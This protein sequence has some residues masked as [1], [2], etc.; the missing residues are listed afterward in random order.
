M[1]FV[2]RFVECLA[3]K[4]PQINYKGM[5]IMLNWI[6]KK[7]EKK[8]LNELGGIPIL[9]LVYQPNK[10][11]PNMEYKLHPSIKHDEY[12]KNQF[13]EIA[14]YLRENYC[15]EWNYLK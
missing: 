15:D 12:L 13:K 14:D 1:S 11:E 2:N 6:N 5:I 10:P 9:W 4:T 3:Q 7:L 8:S